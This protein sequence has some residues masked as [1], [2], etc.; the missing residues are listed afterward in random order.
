MGILAGEPTA[1]PRGGT[2]S[3]AAV[4]QQLDDEDRQTLV[5]WIRNPD[6]ESTAIA[7]HL[8]QHGVTLADQPLQRHRRR[9]C[10]CH[11]RFP[12]WAA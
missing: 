3:V 5:E 1:R 8:A 7:E 9:M 11:D 4:L 10:R 12:E 2:C 6:I